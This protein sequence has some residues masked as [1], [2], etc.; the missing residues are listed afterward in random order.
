MSI[1]KVQGGISLNDS[2]ETPKA[3]SE[4]DKKIQTVASAAWTCM[5]IANAAFTAAFA[6][7]GVIALVNGGVGAALPCVVV[8]I[9]MGLRLLLSRV[10]ANSKIQEAEKYREKA[11]EYYDAITEISYKSMLRGL[12]K[13]IKNSQNAEEIIPPLTSAIARYENFIIEIKKYKPK[14]PGLID[15]FPLLDIDFYGIE[16]NKSMLESYLK[17]FIENKPGDF[18]TW[19]TVTL[20]EIDRAEKT[21][22]KGMCKYCDLLKKIY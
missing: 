14:S 20:D 4:K 16:G 21:L 2:K 6:T 5:D 17:H 19:K 18:Q 1:Y 13:A 9:I 7:L 11:I 8:T 12:H 15:Y 10:H 22:S 3:I